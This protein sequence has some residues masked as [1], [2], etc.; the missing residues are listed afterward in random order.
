MRILLLD[1]EITVLKALKGIL[2]HMGHT[3][4]GVAEAA[5]AVESVAAN[6]YDVIFVDFKMPVHDGI[7]FMKNADI[8]RST[9]VL[10]LT[11]YVNRTVI[12]EMFSLGVRGYLIKPVDEKELRAHLDF[13]APPQTP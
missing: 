7:W 10:L 4:D 9:R 5:T 8:P 13:H 6:E 3:V 2:T 11:A 12:N 1:D